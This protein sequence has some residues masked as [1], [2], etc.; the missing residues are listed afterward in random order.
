MSLLRRTPRDDRFW[1]SLIQANA[2]EF[3][4]KVAMEAGMT[5]EAANAFLDAKP[6][7][8]LLIGTFF[9]E[10]LTKDGDAREAYEDLKIILSTPLMDA[11]EYCNTVLN[12]KA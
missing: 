12:A 11:V 4:K 9:D 8:L 6:V 10:L 3:G 5:G 1:R 2:Y 7:V